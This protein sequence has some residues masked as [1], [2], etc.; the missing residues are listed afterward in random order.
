MATPADELPG[1]LA[2][3]MRRWWREF[4]RQMEEASDYVE[5][6][7]V[8]PSMVLSVRPERSLSW[9]GCSEVLGCRLAPDAESASA[10][11]HFSSSAERL[12]D[13]EIAMDQSV[14]LPRDF[15][16]IRVLPDIAS[17]GDAGS[18]CIQCFPDHGKEG[19]VIAQ[20]RSSQN[21]HWTE[22]TCDH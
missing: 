3:Y 10:R 20:G 18:T 6:E 11:L 7:V 9:F 15:G 19:P 4:D 14:E 5:P 17:D 16:R 1:D 22:T 12:L 21:D 8:I 2:R 13:R